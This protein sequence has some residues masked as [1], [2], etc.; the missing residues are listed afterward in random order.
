MPPV[1]RIAVSLPSLSLSQRD[2]SRERN[3]KA[4]TVLLTMGSAAGESESGSG[5][6]EALPPQLNLLL[7]SC[8]QWR[9]D[10]LGCAHHRTLTT[11]NLD[12]LAAEGVRF[13]KHFGQSAPCSP[14][15]ASLYTGLYA[16]NHRY[17]SSHVA[18]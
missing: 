3:S 6:A 7:I 5:S 18:A 12:A 14:G 10:A 16:M 9:G 13:A 8:D 11:P 15:R 1:A 4:P 17:V 2:L